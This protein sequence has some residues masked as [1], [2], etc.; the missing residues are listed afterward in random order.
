[1][2]LVA[3]F[4]LVRYNQGTVNNSAFLKI[5]FPL[6]VTFM[7]AHLLMQFYQIDLIIKS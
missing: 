6:D 1:M 7:E 5:I 4:Y 3:N 2:F